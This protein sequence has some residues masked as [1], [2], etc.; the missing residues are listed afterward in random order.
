MA[1]WALSERL[2]AIVLRTF[3]V[4]VRIKSRVVV[5]ISSL[6][7]RQTLPSTR[8]FGAADIRACKLRAALHELSLFSM[9]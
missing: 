5:V 6:G 1:L 8:P 3:G 4:Q 7:L 2:W 9:N